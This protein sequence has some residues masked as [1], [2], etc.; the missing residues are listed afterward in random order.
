MLLGNSKDLRA[1]V[2]IPLTIQANDHPANGTQALLIFDG[3]A[4]PNVIY[5]DP[6]PG[7]VELSPCALEITK[8]KL[9]DKQ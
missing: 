7:A 8:G 2:A 4:Y 9:K 3:C 6:C 1:I 5:I